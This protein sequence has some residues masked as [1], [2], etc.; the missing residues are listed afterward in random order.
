MAEIDVPLLRLEGLYQLGGETIRTEQQQGN[1]GLFPGGVE[2]SLDPLVR[3]QG[4]QATQMA[5]PEILAKQDYPG[6]IMGPGRGQQG[7]G[8]QL[9]AWGAT[10]G[11]GPIGQGGGKLGQQHR[12]D[13]FLGDQGV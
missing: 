13:A 2:A 4:R 12:G 7:F 11:G 3:Q 10:E 6:A 8:G 5:G 1:A 9:P